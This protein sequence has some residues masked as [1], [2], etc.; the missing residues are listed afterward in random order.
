[1]VVDSDR[2]DLM[3][4]TLTLALPVISSLEIS[5]RNEYASLIELE[6]NLIQMLEESHEQ[7]NVQGS[8]SDWNTGC[9]HHWDHVNA[10]LRRIHRLE[11]KLGDAM[12]RSQPKSV[13]IT[14]E[15]LLRQEARL[16]FA[17]SGLHSQT[18][19]LNEAA[20]KEWSAL[21]IMV[22]SHRKIVQAHFQRMHLHLHTWATQGRLTVLTTSSARVEPKARWMHVI[23]DDLS[24]CPNDWEFDQAAIE[25]EAEQHQD[26]G[27]VDVVKS[28]FMWVE[29]PEERVLK[30]HDGVLPR[31]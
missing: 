17:L 8:P 10:V 28:L 19:H 23:D 11:A 30:N 18:L 9:Q 25:I 12:S 2:G 14:W 5:L 15:E 27:I 4:I 29:S 24:P 7:E 6:V 16:A 31:A 21:V 3:N 1:M 22:A 13:R 26:L 20:A